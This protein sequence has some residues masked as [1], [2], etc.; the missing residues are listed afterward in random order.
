MYVDYKSQIER[1]PH[2]TMTNIIGH[3]DTKQKCW[4]RGVNISNNFFPQKQLYLETITYRPKLLK[5]L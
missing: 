5:L 2:Q 1:S 3:K 4:D